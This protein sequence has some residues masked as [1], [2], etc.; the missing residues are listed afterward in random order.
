MKTAAD[1]KAKRIVLMMLG[2]IE[3]ATAEDIRSRTRLVIGM[4]K[5]EDPALVIDED[6]LVREVESAWN[7]WVPG[8]IAIED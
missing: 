3:S 2:D 8:P 4:L 5:A 1:E 7:V 6:R